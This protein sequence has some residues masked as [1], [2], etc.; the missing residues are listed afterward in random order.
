MSTANVTN[1][2]PMKTRDKIKYMFAT[3]LGVMT[4]IAIGGLFMARY[5]REK[6]TAEEDMQ[7]QQTL[8]IYGADG[9]LPEKVQL[10]A[11]TPAIGPVAE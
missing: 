11:G 9:G 1:R 6:T 2:K 5:H 7:V 10:P 4:I 8:M 3:F